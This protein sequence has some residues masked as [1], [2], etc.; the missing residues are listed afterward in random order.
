VVGGC[1]VAG[2]WRATV[3]LPANAALVRRVHPLPATATLSFACTLR[4]REP[5][6]MAVPAASSFTLEAH[7]SQRA[8]RHIAALESSKMG[9]AG[10]ELRDTWQHWSPPQQGGGVRSYGTRDGSRALLS[11]E[12]GFGAAGHVAACGSTSCSLS[13]PHARM[14][15]YPVY[16]VPTTAKI[17]SSSLERVHVMA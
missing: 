4:T 15:G 1:I 14:W 9:R 3:T 8:T 7:D 16:R 17:I 6:C 12:A 11:W 5:S 10:L 13:W 2:C